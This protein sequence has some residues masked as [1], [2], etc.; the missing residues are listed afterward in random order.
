KS[1]HHDAQAEKARY[2][3]VDVAP[4]RFF[5]FVVLGG[6]GVLASSGALH[7][8]VGLLPGEDTF[9]ASWIEEI[10]ERL[11]R[12][13]GGNNHKIGFIGAQPHTANAVGAR[14]HFEPAGCG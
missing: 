4:A 13:S 8:V 5:E 9:T 10:V 2:Q 14:R 11:I 3:E 6:E 12:S 7:C 1:A